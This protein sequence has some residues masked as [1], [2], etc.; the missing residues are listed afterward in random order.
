LAVAYKSDNNSAAP[1]QM[2]VLPITI[3]QFTISGSGDAGWQNIAV[4]QSMG[5]WW[6]AS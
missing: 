2:A 1:T 5:S 4:G 6:P 3:P